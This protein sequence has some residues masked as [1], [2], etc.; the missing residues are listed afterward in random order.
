VD[1]TTA[2]GTTTTQSS[3]PDTDTDATDTDA[4]DTDATGT[5]TGGA[6]CGDGVIEGREVCDDRGESKTCNADCTAAECGDGVTNESAGEACDDAGDSE[7]CD[8][9]CSTAECGDMTVNA[10]AGEAC[11][12]GEET[13]TCNADCNAAECGDGVLN[14]TAGESCDEGGESATCDT[15]CSAAECGD[16]LLNVSAGEE[17][18]G[19]PGCSDTCVVTCAAFTADMFDANTTFPEAALVGTSAGM[20]WDGAN[21][22]SVTGGTVVGDRAAQHGADGTVNSVFAPGIDFRSVFTL[23][24]GTATVYARDFNSPTL[25]V[26]GAPG[27]F[28]ND[29]T[30]AT[31]EPNLDEQSA[32]VWNDDTDEFVA[33]TLGVILR[34]S[35]DG[36]FVGITTL[37]GFGDDPAELEFP[38]NRSLAW[39]DGC[40]LTYA[41]GAL[42][43]WDVAGAQ[44]DTTTLTGA[45]TNLDAELSVSYANGEVFVADGTDWRGFSVW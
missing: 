1:P 45:G 25:R 9:D 43:S 22:Y 38:S 30:L 44:V 16:G 27:V 18:D 8:A 21:F 12:D 5:D 36:T 17:C 39:A 19:G 3:G 42:S 13:E 20:A 41:D 15:D 23:G 7:S 14:E 24:D 10:A 11:D 34:W 28:T 2:P 29:V 6:V 31:S 37:Q 4:T 32:V 40:Y 33:L 26:M 35:S